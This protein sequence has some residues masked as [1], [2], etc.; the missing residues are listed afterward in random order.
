MSSDTE[1]LSN[2]LRP[3]R[4]PLPNRR[5]SLTFG[6]EAGGMKYRAIISRF[7]GGRLAEIFLTKDAEYQ[8]DGGPGFPKT[9][10]FGPADAGHIDASANRRK[11]PDESVMRGTMPDNT[12]ERWNGCSQ[13]AAMSDAVIISLIRRACRGS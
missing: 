7:A 1:I 8:R 5:A 9:K 3:R 2:I 10:Q 6:I 4:R 13:G 12:T 11:F